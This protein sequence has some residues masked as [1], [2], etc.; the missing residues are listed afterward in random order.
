[1]EHPSNYGL[2]MRPLEPGDAVVFGLEQ[3][4]GRAKESFGEGPRWR[5]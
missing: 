5:A 1:M 2:R 3:A 4:G